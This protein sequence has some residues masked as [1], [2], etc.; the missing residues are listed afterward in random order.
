MGVKSW[1]RTVMEAYKLRMLDNG[2]L[3][4]I[5][6]RRSE[7][8]I[9]NEKNVQGWFFLSIPFRAFLVH[10]SL[11]IQ[12]K[13]TYISPTCFDVFYAIF[14]EGY[15]YFCSMQQISIG[16]NTVKKKHV[17]FERNTS[18]PPWKWCI[19]PG[20]WFIKHDGGQHDNLKS[21]VYSNYAG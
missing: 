15:S 3:S 9:G 20:Q 12:T 11:Y 10:S 5:V 16:N 19:T 4:G 6:V 13:C 17:V 18:S 21:L 7:A 2:L 14:R 1:F 8:R